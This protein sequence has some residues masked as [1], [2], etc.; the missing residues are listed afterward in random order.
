M[1][2]EHIG[3]AEQRLHG[4]MFKVVCVPVVRE[5]TGFGYGC[6]EHVGIGQPVDYPACPALELPCAWRFRA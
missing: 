4:S 3:V 5:Y 6:H 1:V 2:E